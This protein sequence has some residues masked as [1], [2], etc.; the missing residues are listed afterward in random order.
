MIDHLIACI[1][2]KKNY[3][4]LCSAVLPSVGKNSPPALF[5]PG[6]THQ[7]LPHHGICVSETKKYKHKLAMDPSF[8]I[9]N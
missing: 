7:P 2:A 8:S 5:L 4:K 6:I 3:S 1:S 9:D